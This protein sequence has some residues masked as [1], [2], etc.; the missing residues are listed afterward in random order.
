MNEKEIIMNVSFTQFK[1]FLLDLG[2]DESIDDNT[3]MLNDQELDSTEISEL[4]TRIRKEYKVEIPYSHISEKKLCEILD[5]INRGVEL[6]ET[7]NL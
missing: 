5:D 3:N 6:H 2:Y 7:A 1:K 4:C